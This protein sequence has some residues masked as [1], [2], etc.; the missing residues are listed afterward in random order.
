M[1]CLGVALNL[2]RCQVSASPTLGVASHSFCEGV[3]FL[4]C[5]V[6]VSPSSMLYSIWKGA[7]LPYCHLICEGAVQRRFGE[8][9]LLIF[10]G[11]K[12]PSGR[13]AESHSIC[14]GVKSPSCQVVGARES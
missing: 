10:Q 9:S 4:H 14:E 8:S 11:A 12:L 7:A 3:E 6:A 2:R 1:P 13:V 5:Q